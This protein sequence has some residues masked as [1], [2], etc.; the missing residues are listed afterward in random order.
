MFIAMNRFRIAR[1]SEEAFEQ[2]WLNRDSQLNKVPGFVEFHLLK[3]PEAEDHTLY[4]SHTVWQSKSAF[5]GLDQVRGVPRGAC[6]GRQQHDRAA[7]SRASEVRRLRGPPDHRARRAGGRLTAMTAPSFDLSPPHGG[8]S[9]RRVRDR[10]QRARRHA[11]RR[12]RGAAG[13][14]APARARRGVHRRHGR[15]R[16]MGRRDADR[17]HRRRHHGV[18]RADPG[19]AGQARLFQSH[20]LDRLP[21]P[22]PA[23]ALR[24]A[25]LRRAAVHEQALGGDRVL[26]SRRRHHVQGLRRPRREA[27]AQGRSACGVPRARR[28]ALQG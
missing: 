10:R 9:R 13:R 5:R 15:H 7:L 24:R 23:R 26:Q 8:E 21:R 11:A 1:G 20:G 17:P 12:G 3:G 6:A 14:D 22:S 19:R 28:A 25:R 27:R 16:Q 18:H 4:A 2:V